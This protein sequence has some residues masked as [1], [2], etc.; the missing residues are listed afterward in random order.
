MCKKSYLKHNDK[1]TTEEGGQGIAAE[2]KAEV[3]GLLRR[4]I[5]ELE[6]DK[7]KR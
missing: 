1:L 7:A 5:R 2:R 4:K 6:K 3:V